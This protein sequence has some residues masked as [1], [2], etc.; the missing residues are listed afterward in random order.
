MFIFCVETMGGHFS[1]N[2]IFF[3]KNGS[4]V[5]PQAKVPMQKAPYIDPLVMMDS[6]NFEFFVDICQQTLSFCQM[7]CS[8]QFQ[9][10]SYAVKTFF[11]FYNTVIGYK[12][13]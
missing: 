10:S 1:E 2:P 11:C 4:Q 8:K 9:G 13:I 7:I 12:G 5:A 3:E 6:P